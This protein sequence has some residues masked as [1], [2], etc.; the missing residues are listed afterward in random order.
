MAFTNLQMACYEA[1][2]LGRSSSFKFRLTFS[3]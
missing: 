1:L 3:L 2:E